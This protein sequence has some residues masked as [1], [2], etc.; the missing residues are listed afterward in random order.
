MIARVTVATLS[1]LLM[2]LICWQGAVLLVGN[3]YDSAAQVAAIF[4]HRGVM[5]FAVGISALRVSWQV[6]GM[7]VGL[8]VGAP[9]AMSALTNMESFGYGLWTVL[10]LL[11]LGAVYGFLIE[12]ITTRLFRLPARG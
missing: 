5:G 11:P 6:N 2:G 1:G 3:Q 12:L 7:I 8:V 9:F 10:A 4:V